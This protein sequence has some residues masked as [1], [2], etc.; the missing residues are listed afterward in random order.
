MTRCMVL[1][2]GA[3]SFDDL[4][5][6]SCI[7]VPASDWSEV[8]RA[9]MDVSA[10]ADGRKVHLSCAAAARAETLAGPARV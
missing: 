5:M 6:R 1:P 2:C 10:H 3:R 4:V 7:N 8:L 9:I